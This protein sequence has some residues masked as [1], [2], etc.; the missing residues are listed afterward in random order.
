MNNANGAVDRIKVGLGIGLLAAL[1]GC[2]GYVDGGYVEPAI[3][4]EPPVVFLGG[5]YERGH[6]VHAYSHRGAES[7]AIAHRGEPRRGR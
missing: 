7:R 1:T 6:D 3:W 2:I 5:F 4:P